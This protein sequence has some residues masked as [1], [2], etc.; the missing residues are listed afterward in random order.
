MRARADGRRPRTSLQPLHPR[1]VRERE[2]ESKGEREWESKRERVRE[3]EC[4]RERGRS[5]GSERE[6]SLPLHPRLVRAHHST[7]RKLQFDFSLRLDKSH[8]L[9]TIYP[10]LRELEPGMA[11]AGPS[12]KSKCSFGS[13]SSSSP[14]AS[15]QGQQ[16][17]SSN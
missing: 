6:T 3:K 16:P 13:L 17:H 4:E 8:F 15:L 9:R 2:R 11:L 7:S 1:L 5:G 14:S 12:N 10:K